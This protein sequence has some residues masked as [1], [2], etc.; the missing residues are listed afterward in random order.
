MLSFLPSADSFPNETK[1]NKE[2]KK[3]KMEGKIYHFE[4]GSSKKMKKDF[5]C[6]KCQ[7]HTKKYSFFSPKMTHKKRRRK[8]QDIS[9]LFLLYIHTA[10]HAIFFLS[11]PFHIIIII[12][13]LVVRWKGKYSKK[14][15]EKES[16]KDEERRKKRGEK[17]EKHIIRKFSSSF[18]LSREL[19]CHLKGCQKQA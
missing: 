8:L 5:N 1:R 3:S 14:K 6:L 18:P 13:S 7:Y 2:E 17:N 15:W 12:I 19:N 11:L 10:Y 4:Q 16:C 9:F